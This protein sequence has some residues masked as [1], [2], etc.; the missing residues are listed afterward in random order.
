MDGMKPIL[1]SAAAAAVALPLLYTCTASVL[2]Q[3]LP[4][5]RNKRICLLIAHPDDEA[6]F[7]APTVLA[8]TR[9][10]LAN[11]V[12]ILCLSTG[13]QDGLGE[14][15]ARELKK[16]AKL[17]GL[18]SEDDTLVLDEPQFPD[19]ITT[20]WDAGDIAKLLS[21][22]FSPKDGR[23]IDVLLTFD[24]AG[25]SSHPNHTSLYHGARKYIAAL[26][27]GGRPANA[28]APVDL[29]TL[30][31]VNVARKYSG[32]L[33]VFPTLLGLTG[34]VAR[35]TTAQGNPGKLVAAAGLFGGRESAAT[36]RAAM[37]QAHQSQM[38]WFRWGWITLSR[39]MY[40]NE[41]RLESGKP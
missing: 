17:L 33:D 21:R 38:V 4:T 14:T 40:V 35:T 2:A 16:S 32:F 15:R 5:L 27:K 22:A 31:S 13:N 6:M 8:L 36:A 28:A 9:P 37:T 12:K 39:Y 34:A 26:A 11:D 20:K 25:V 19:S 18:R 23:A 29:Y 24:A 7:F 30:T 3:R 41:L 10:E 1:T